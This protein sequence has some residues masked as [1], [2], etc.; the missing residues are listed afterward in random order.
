MDDLESLVGSARGLSGDVYWTYD[1]V[2]FPQIWEPPTTDALGVRGW[3][4]IHTSAKIGTGVEEAFAELARRMV[5]Y[6]LGVTP[7]SCLNRR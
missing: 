4:V 3:H 6:A 5:A 2:I 1:V 7:T